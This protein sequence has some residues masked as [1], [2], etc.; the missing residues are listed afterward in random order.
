MEPGHAHKGLLAGNIYCVKSVKHPDS[1]SKPSSVPRDAM[2][3]ADISQI[4]MKTGWAQPLTRRTACRNL[5]ITNGIATGD[6]M[7]QQA[8]RKLAA[9]AA[10]IP[11]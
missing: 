7:Q 10:V 3:R 6:G 5:D 9:A 2:Q 4:P 11:L 1:T 8:K